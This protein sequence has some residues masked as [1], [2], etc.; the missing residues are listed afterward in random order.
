MV[1]SMTM[2]PTKKMTAKGKDGRY[3][4]EHEGRLIYEWE[5]SLEEVNI[6]IQAPPNVKKKMIDIVIQH[7][8]LKVYDVK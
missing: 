8:H 5:Q 6:Y 2:N 7:K 1:D 3:K 4:F